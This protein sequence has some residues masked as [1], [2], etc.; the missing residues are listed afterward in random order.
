[1]NSVS[2]NGQWQYRI[3]RGPFSPVTVPFSRLPVGHSECTRHFD[4]PH[5]SER[6]FLK[7][8]GITYYSKVSLNG[9]V[10]GEMLPYCEYEFDITDIVK[11]KDN[12]LLVELEDIDRAF[13]P[14]EGWENFGGIIRDVHLL[15]RESAY[16]EN[17][18]F[19]PTLSPDLRRAEIR[20][21]T[22]AVCPADACFTVTLRDGARPVLFY[23][24]SP[25][26]TVTAAMDSIRLWSPEDP[27]LYTLE[28]QLCSGGQVMD[29]YT[30]EVGLRS[31]THDGRH[32]FLN[33]KELFL[34][35]VCK[36]EM[37]GDSGH[38]PTVR[39]MENDMR[40]IKDMGCNFVRLVHYPHHREM[41]RIADRMG[42]LVS[43]EPGLWWS[44]VSR[45]EVAEGSK[46]VLRRTILLDRNHPSIAFWLCFNECKFTEQFLRDSAAVCREYDPTRMVSGANCMSD[47]DTLLYYDKC[48]FD[49]YT[50]HPYSDTFARAKR[51]AEILQGK[52]LLF[53]EWGGYHVYDNPHLLTDFMREMR[54]LYKKESGSTLAGAFFWFFAELNDFNRGA[55]ACT[56]GRLHEGLV[57]L[58]RRP[59]AITE[60]FCRGLRILDGAEEEEA[61]FW[62]EDAEAYADP[63]DLRP[64]SC[65]DTP[66]A[67]A[68]LSN[69]R[70]AWADKGVMRRRKISR[71]P[72]LQDRAPLAE[73]PHTV[74]AGAPLIFEGVIQTDRITVL[75]LMSA[76]SGY[77][78]G[79]RYGEQIARMT[80]VYADGSA[81]THIL[82]NGVHLTTAF[83]LN[84]SSRIDPVAEEARR[85]ALFGRNRNFE[86][87]VMNRLDIAADA[88]KEIRRVE[89]TADSDRYLPLIYGVFAK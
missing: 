10:L 80:V 74:R 3:G 65:P 57:D 17:V 68:L 44:D 11:A 56:D 40:M 60:A 23:T 18:F 67:D 4:L 9:S 29:T 82:E 22:K 85:F 31:I 50:M 2:L 48:G 88:S 51:S 33:G 64:L 77:P 26:E 89:F 72:V 38:C 15:L 54:R 45:E 55:P 14:S 1:M 36:H 52:P 61:P 6:I 83:A 53:T 24:Q 19:C 87:Y 75:G 58:Y 79:G 70:D 5:S 66:C 81:E 34:K 86:I 84:G 42:L 78:L 27:H 73:I 69:I 46:E 63:G 32:F 59:T 41:L 62:W 37:V 28:V 12:E 16:I 35:G 43:E 7:L 47:E 21:E 25:S 71:G 39:Q 76:V 20:V 49:F 30:C 8:D 13:G